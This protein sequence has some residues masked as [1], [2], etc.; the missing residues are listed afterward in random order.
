VAVSVLTFLPCG[1]WLCSHRRRRR[2]QVEAAAGGGLASSP[3]RKK[4]PRPAELQLTRIRGISLGSL[5]Q[6]VSPEVADIVQLQKQRARALRWRARSQ[7]SQKANRASLVGAVWLSASIGLI[8]ANWTWLQIFV[9][10]YND[11]NFVAMPDTEER[12]LYFGFAFNTVNILLQRAMVATFTRAESHRVGTGDTTFE[13]YQL[14]NLINLGGALYSTIYQQSLFVEQEE[15][16]EFLSFTAPTILIKLLWYILQVCDWWHLATE[17]YPS[18]SGGGK[19]SFDGWTKGCSSRW[20]LCGSLIWCLRCGKDANPDITNTRGVVCFTS[21]LQI[22]AVWVSSCQY[23]APQLSGMLHTSGAAC[24]GVQRATCNVQR[25]ARAL[26]TLKL[27]CAYVCMTAVARY[28]VFLLLLKAFPKNVPLF[29]SYA[30]V[31][32]EQNDP[33]NEHLFRQQIFFTGLALGIESVFYMATN[34]L[35]RIAKLPCTPS[36]VGLCHLR[37]FPRYK[38]SIVLIG[39]HIVSDVYLGMIFA[40]AERGVAVQ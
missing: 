7:T 16:G 32:N 2:L 1:G 19:G 26:R 24:P 31:I 34:Q 38:L 15:I 35:S 13:R 9:A 20:G 4:R 8:I 39:G 17:R 3:S 21:F 25:A 27:T 10:L 40:D 5:V 22:T 29:P 37:E 30:E 28:I 12:N 23:V 6:Q 18:L 11:D 36:Y 14:V 33:D